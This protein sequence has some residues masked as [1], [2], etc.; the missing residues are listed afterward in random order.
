MPASQDPNLDINYGWTYRESGWKDGMD[1][2][3]KKLGAVVHLGVIEVGRNTPPGSPSE[4]DRYIVGSS[5]TDAWAS[6]AGDL[7]VYIDSAWE[8]HTPQEAWRLWD[9]G[10]E[11]ALVFDGSSWRPLGHA[12]NSVSTTRTI[13]GER[14]LFCDTG[15]G[16]YDVTLPDATTTPGQIIRI[17]KT[18]TD[19]NVITVKTAGGSIEGV[20]GS[21]GVAM[22][23][24][25]LS[26]RSYV[27]DGTDYWRCADA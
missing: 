10:E 25:G 17:V 19:S 2:N 16:A 8:F 4:G 3:M 27:S 18:T 22:G 21:T 6:N 7:A 11:T 14:V 15:W 20:A 13:S 24:G 9:Q 5:P 1:A 26:S 12:I 23:S